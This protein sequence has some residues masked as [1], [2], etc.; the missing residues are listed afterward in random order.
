MHFVVIQNIMRA[1]KRLRPQFHL[2]PPSQTNSGPR[3][4]DRTGFILFLCGLTLLVTLMM[5][6]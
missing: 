3:R 2:R 6:L 5:L 1:S 4:R